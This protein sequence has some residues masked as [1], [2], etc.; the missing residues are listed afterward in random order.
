[1]IELGRQG[2]VTQDARR[3]S[4]WK[5]CRR[6]P[7]PQAPKQRG[8][9]RGRGKRWEPDAL[10]TKPNADLRQELGVSKP[11][12]GRKLAPGKKAERLDQLKQHPPRCANAGRVPG[13][14]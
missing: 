10:A 6:T 13:G 2:W 9:A 7:G 14:D 3:P 5:G 1:M 8:Q 4:G 11:N 12:L